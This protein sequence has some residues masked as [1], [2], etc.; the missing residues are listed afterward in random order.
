MRHFWSGYIIWIHSMPTKKAPSGTFQRISS[1]IFIWLIVNDIK[2]A[3][4]KTETEKSYIF[5]QTT[6][7][8]KGNIEILWAR[9]PYWWQGL[10]ADHTNSRM[11]FTSMAHRSLQEKWLSRL[12][13]K[14]ELT[15]C[16]RP[17]FFCHVN[18]FRAFTALHTRNHTLCD[19]KQKW[20]KQHDNETIMELFL[21]SF[22]LH[23]FMHWT[24][25]WTVKLFTLIIT[26]MNINWVKR[27]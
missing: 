8:W 26:F 11:T 9:V 16:R 14:L 23:I 10:N 22:L 7:W 4:T 1:R 20:R 15:V 5:A 3:K 12:N 27:E 6:L 24:F 25:C 21:F 19:A 18:A 2:E 13:K 17:H